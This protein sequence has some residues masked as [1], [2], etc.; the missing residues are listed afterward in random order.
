LHGVP[1]R[2][3]DFPGYHVSQPITPIHYS[4]PRF[5]ADLLSKRDRLSIVNFK[6]E[7][8]GESE[9]VGVKLVSRNDLIR[10][11]V[12]GPNTEEHFEKIRPNYDFLIAGVD[13]GGGG[14]S[15]IS[16]TTIAIIGYSY[17]KVHVIRGIRLDMLDPFQEIMFLKDYCAKHRIPIVAH[18]AN[19]SGSLREILLHKANISDIIP[20]QY[21]GQITGKL[22]VRRVGKAQSNMRRVWRLHKSRSLQILCAAIKSGEI[23]F[24]DYTDDRPDGPNLL[25][26]FLSLFEER[27]ENPRGEDQYLIQR[28]P[29]LSDDFV[30]AVNFACVALWELRGLWPDFA[31]AF[32][33]IEEL[34]AQL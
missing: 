33:D 5:W 17:G 9:E 1:S 3:Y 21:V 18:D 27:I 6:R 14:E 13:W 2:R 28:N 15:G 34:P 26:H 30:H 29:A 16:R 12:L 8:L 10:A 7:V 23:L 31:Q 24:F 11:A 20:I 22:L 19:P 4:T 25:V 32:S